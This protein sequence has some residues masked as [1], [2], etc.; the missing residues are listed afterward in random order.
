VCLCCI[1]YWGGRDPFLS[2]RPFQ[3][4]MDIHSKWN[5]SRCRKRRDECGSRPTGTKLNPKP[6]Q[7]RWK[8]PAPFEIRNSYA[9]FHTFIFH[10]LAKQRRQL[11]MIKRLHFFPVAVVVRASFRFRALFSK[12]PSYPLPLT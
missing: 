6:I 10:T 7:R 9:N 5:W 4:A 12:P 8:E 2:N 1:H 3:V 11:K